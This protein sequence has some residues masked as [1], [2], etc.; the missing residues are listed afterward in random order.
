[1]KKVT[2]FTPAYD[3][4][5]AAECVS[6]KGE[7]SGSPNPDNPDEEWICDECGGVIPDDDTKCVHGHVS[8][9]DCATCGSRI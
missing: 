8:A 4:G 6:G 7:W 1:M 2:G 5:H 9:N 3:I